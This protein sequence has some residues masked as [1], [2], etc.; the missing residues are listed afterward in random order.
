M[1]LLLYRSLSALSFYTT[2]PVLGIR[3]PLIQDAF[4]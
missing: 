4:L 2:D 1:G 3:R